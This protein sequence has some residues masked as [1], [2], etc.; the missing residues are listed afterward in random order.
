MFKKLLRLTIYTAAAGLLA[1]IAFTAFLWLGTNGVKLD[2]NKL[3]HASKQVV[4]YDKYD[5]QIMQTAG[6]GRTLV[7]ISQLN[8]YTKQAFC[9]VEDKN[10]YNHNGIDVKRIVSAT[11]K[12]IASLSYAQGASTITQQLIKNTQLSSEKTM[13]RKAKEIRLA[14]ELEKLYSKDEILEMYLNTIYFGSGCYGIE[15]AS[16]MY[17]GKQAKDLTLAESAALAGLIKS[18]ANYSPIMNPEACIKRR[19]LVLGLMKQQGLINPQDHEAACQEQIAAVSHT[20]ERIDPYVVSGFSEACT[21]LGL[22]ERE[23]AQ[24]GYKIFTYLD[25]D[26]NDQAKK[27]VQDKKYYAEYYENAMSCIVLCSNE[28]MGIEVFASKNVYDF[29]SFSRQTGSALKPLA[30]YAPAFEKNFV[31]PAT[32]MEDEKTDFGGYCPQNFDGKYH[33]RVSVRYALSHSLNIPAVKLLNGIGTRYSLDFL[34]GMDISVG[35]SSLTAALGATANPVPLKR[36]LGGYGALAN[37]GVYTSPSFI[38][39]IV[40]SNGNTVYQHESASARVMRDDTAFLITDILRD[41]VASGT[42]VRLKSLPYEVAAKTGTVGTEKGNSDAYSL[43][44][45]TAHTLLSFIGNEKTLMSNSIMGGTTPSIAARDFYNVLYF[46]GGPQPFSPPPS[47]KSADIDLYALEKN[48]TLLLAGPDAPKGTVLREWFSMSNYPTQTSDSFTNPKV[49]SPDI[50]L[51]EN[52]PHISFV[53]NKYFTYKIYRADDNSIVDEISG[54]EG[55]IDI[56]DN[57]ARCGKISEYII[58]PIYYSPGGVQYQGLSFA[59]K[60]SVPFDLTPDTEDRPTAPLPTDDETSDDELW[61]Q[62]FG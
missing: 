36:L 18:P 56:T 45:T 13:L 47:V 50:R 58:L 44:Y 41:S 39:K 38:R 25:K 37:L 35:E 48:Q 32:I 17:F 21:L 15:A 14:L 43:S 40:D 46:S 51:K 20:S 23:L 16:A 22:N 3:N 24:G 1:G 34:S 29:N 28:S 6:A 54:K 33:G 7:N 60:I 30:V 19:N 4:L 2:A 59:Q 31:A 55:R 5:N 57:Q 52:R 11:V 8:E 62:Q 42:A 49:Q 9:A 61:W 12:N 26:L 53:A 27:I 10:F